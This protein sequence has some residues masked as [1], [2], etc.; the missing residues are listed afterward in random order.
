MKKFAVDDSD[1]LA[2][3][4]AGLI[5]DESPET[6]DYLESKARKVNINYM[7]D[8]FTNYGTY[9][10]SKSLPTLQRSAE[11]L[12]SIGGSANGNV[13]R[14]YLAVSTLIKIAEDLRSR[15]ESTG[16]GNAG[17]LA[18]SVSRMIADIVK[19]E[20]DPMLRER[21]GDIK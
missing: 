6:L 20:S 5:E 19:N 15:Q 16:D 21:Y 18:G 8:F 10:N 12:K 14:K 11:F 3:T 7:F 13:Y 4:F 1:Y 9:L 17:E 2:G